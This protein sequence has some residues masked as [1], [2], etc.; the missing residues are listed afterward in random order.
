MSVMN[1]LS[2]FDGMSCGQIAIREHGF[3]IDKYYAS[4]VD[5]FAIQQTQYNFPDTIQLGD[6][7]N[8]RTWDID[9]S[10]IDLILAGSPC[11][12]FSFA[13]LGLAFDDPRSK[14][15][16]VFVE[17]LKHC[18]KHNTGVKF[19][20]ENVDMK[21]EY[22]RII[23]EY[24]GVFPVSI[25]SALVSAQNRCRWYWSDIRVKKIGLFDEVYTNIPQPVD[26]GV[27]LRDIL[28]PENEVD[29][30][31][32]LSSVALD[33]I[34]RKAYSNPQINPNKTGAINT[35]NNSGQLSV[36]SGT[37]LISEG[38]VS[39]S[40]KYNNSGKSEPLT[41]HNGCAFD[42]CLKVDRN[43][44][45]KSNQDKADSLTIGGHGCGNHSD[46]DLIISMKLGRSPGYERSN[47]SNKAYALDTSGKDGFY[48][49]SQLRR[50]TPV[51]CA[52][53]QTIPDWYKW[54]VSDSQIYRMLGNGW[55]IKV[56]KHIISFF[57][58]NY[59]K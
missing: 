20:L 19:L 24:V 3:I 5:R 57:E 53:L 37:T 18:R 35:K 17:I 42:M 2:C 25:N 10:S 44:V 59:L 46:M 47:A 38:G 28:Q 9:W 14:L 56:I 30:K 36:D 21:K 34:K 15:F 32:Y 51:E 7:N 13:G 49:N 33:R 23:S 6:I 40:V 22:L 43:G 55:T 29:Q 50:L 48:M 27:L 45:P 4:E 26:E 58:P 12:G 41:S 16:F 54:I 11:Q 31:Y 39:G 52:R 1:I 8:W